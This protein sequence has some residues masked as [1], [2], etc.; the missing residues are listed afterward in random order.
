M[1]NVIRHQIDPRYIMALDP[2]VD[3]PVWDAITATRKKAAQYYDKAVGYGNDVKAAIHKATAAREVST[4]AHNDV[5]EAMNRLDAHLTNY[6]RMCSLPEYNQEP[7]N[8]LVRMQPIPV[9]YQRGTM[10]M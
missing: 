3:G 7:Q 10:Y 4:K 8:G 2:H 1:S 6:S 5:V 9:A